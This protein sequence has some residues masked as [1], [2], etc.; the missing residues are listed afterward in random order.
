MPAAPRPRSATAPTSGLTLIELVVT[1]SISVI[2]MMVALP[3]FNDATIGG[4]LTSYANQLV[5]S[6]YLARGEAIKRDAAVTLCVTADGSSCMNDADE[7]S[8][9]WEKGWIVLAPDGVTV[10]QRQAALGAGFVA[11]SSVSQLVFEPHGAGAAPATLKFCRNTPTTG[12][13]EKVVAISLTG[14]TMVSTTHDG[15]CP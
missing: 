14:Q 9:R 11:K 5:S 1:V 13:Q 7:A 2:L 4:K 10:I 8:R 6:A 12:T 3:A 15:V